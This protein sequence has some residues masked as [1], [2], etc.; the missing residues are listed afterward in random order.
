MVS[1]CW[2]WLCISLFVSDYCWVVVGVGG[3]CGFGAGMLVWCFV[4][5]CL[6]WVGFVVGLLWVC[7]WLFG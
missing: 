4:W 3:C 7:G 6:G 1:G 2:D 5:V